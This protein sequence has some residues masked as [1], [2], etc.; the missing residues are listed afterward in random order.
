[1]IQIKVLAFGIAKDIVPKHEFDLQFQNEITVGELKNQFISD[2]PDFRKLASLKLAV[3]GHYVEDTQSLSDR[4]E[5]A[6]IP[7]VSG[8]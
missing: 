6:I 7:P 2:Y 1:M 4:D 5:V 3:N 8:G